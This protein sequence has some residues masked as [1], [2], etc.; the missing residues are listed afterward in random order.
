MIYVSN[1]ANIIL[2]SGKACQ[3]RIWHCSKKFALEKS[4]ITHLNDK[5]GKKAQI[6]HSKDVIQQIIYGDML[7]HHQKSSDYKFDILLGVYKLC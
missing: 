1:T 4:I 3:I 6:K 7:K 5:K 2:V